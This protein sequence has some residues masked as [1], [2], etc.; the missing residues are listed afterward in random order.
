MLII[1]MYSCTYHPIRLKSPNFK[2]FETNLRI[3][4]FKSLY[5]ESN[6]FERKKIKECICYKNETSN[7]KNS[8]L[9]EKMDVIYFD[10]K[11]CEMGIKYAGQKDRYKKRQDNLKLFNDTSYWLGN[12]HYFEFETDSAFYYYLTIYNVEKGIGKINTDSLIVK[13]KNGAKSFKTVNF[14]Y[15]KN[16]V[17]YNVDG[18]IVR[19]KFYFNK[20]KIYK[21]EI[22]RNNSRVYKKIHMKYDQ[23]SNITDFI[24]EN[25]YKSKTIAK[26]K[27]YVY[28]N[29][30]LLVKI[31]NFN[32]SNSLV[33]NYLNENDS[34]N[35]ISLRSLDET[36]EYNFY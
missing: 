26:V 6:V 31:Q 16:E 14:D 28:D 23:Y 1:L 25:N 13:Y 8:L 5:F 19:Q 9:Y 15:A 35:L 4:D 18:K 12:K 17:K 3:P 32:L 29:N 30:G 11:G 7:S 2:I 10:E 36:F 20:S 22:F 33:Y 27:K 21:I 24:V 34:S